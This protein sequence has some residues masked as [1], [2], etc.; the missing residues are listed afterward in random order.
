L[1]GFSLTA[2]RASAR[3]ATGF[4]LTALR[5]TLRAAT[6]VSVTGTMKAVLGVFPT[7]FRYFLQPFLILYY[8]PLMIM[9]SWVGPTRTSRQE[10]LKAH[11]KF[12]EG[13]KDAVQ[14]A[15]GAQ[16]GGYWPIHVDEDGNIQAA[17]PPEPDLIIGNF[18]AE[19][20]NKVDINDAI[21]RSVEVAESMGNG[22]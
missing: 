14:V 9:R 11:E 22:K 2:F 13:W 4:S 21:A 19:G 15:E 6:G 18:P 10:A 8:T 20:L 16:E 5:A 12:V 1:T 3:A 17:L 7:W